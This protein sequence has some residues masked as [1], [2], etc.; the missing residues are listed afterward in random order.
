MR[1]REKRCCVT[2]RTRRRILDTSTLTR[3]ISP[4]PFWRPGSVSDFVL[5]L[6][7]LLFL[8]IF[9]SSFHLLFPAPRFSFIPPIC[10]S[11][12]LL[13][14]YSSL[15]FFTVSVLFHCFFLHS[16]SL[17]LTGFLFSSFLSSLLSSFLTSSLLSSLFPLSFFPPPFLL[18][19]FL[20]L[21]FLLSSLLPAFFILSS[22][23]S[24]CPLPAFLFITLHFRQ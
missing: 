12:L 14:F 22:F 6:I 8:S 23:L 1:I 18:L 7:Y 20:L 5:L 24:S 16:P 19:S 9:W 21:S 2:R 3:R 13:P 4:S 11:I 10:S 17:L 15:S